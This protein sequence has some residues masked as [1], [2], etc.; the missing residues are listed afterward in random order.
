MEWMPSY[1]MAA[2]NSEQF[3]PYYLE[4]FINIWLSEYGLIFNIFI[5]SGSM[6]KN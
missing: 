4:F 2:A 1:L 5:M 6:Q 3:H